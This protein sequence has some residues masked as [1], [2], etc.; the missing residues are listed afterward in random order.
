MGDDIMDMGW[1]QHIANQD[2]GYEGACIAHA[3]THGYTADEAMA[4]ITVGLER[5]NVQQEMY[6]LHA[7][8]I[9]EVY[10]EPEE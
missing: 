2:D 9:E 1:S 8:W 6:A 4:I 7:V 10:E 5:E 3:A